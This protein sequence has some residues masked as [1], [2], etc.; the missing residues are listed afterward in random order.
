[1]VAAPAVA[2]LPQTRAEFVA[3]LVRCLNDS[4]VPW[5]WQGPTGAPAVW[6]GSDGPAD[7][8]IWWNPTPDGRERA[9][10]AVRALA[11]MAVI[12]ESRD[13]RRLQHLSLAVEIAASLAVVDF[14]EG[15]LRVGPVLLVPAADVVVSADGIDGAAGPHLVGVAGAADLLVRPL[16]RAKIPPDERLAQARARWRAADPTARLDAARRWGRELGAD[17]AAVLDVLDGAPPPDDLAQRMRRRLLKRTVAPAGLRAAWAQ[18]WSVVPAGRSAG[19]LDLRTRGVVVALVGTDGSGKSTV[20]RDLESRLGALGYRTDEAYFGMARGNLPGVALARRVLGIAAEPD[21]TEA[22][23]PSPE[24]AA[25]AAND[26]SA[27]LAEASEPAAPDLSHAGI[28]Q[29]AAWFY[30]VEYGWRYLRHVA[31]GVRRRAVVVCDR[32]VYD[33]R[34][35]P[36]PGSPAATFAQ[37]LVPAPDVLVL[38]DAPAELIHARKPE[39]RLAEQAQQQQE[40]RDLLAE[41]PARCAELVLDTSGDDPDPVAPAVA[42]VVEASHRPRP[43]RRA[44]RALRRHDGASARA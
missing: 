17:S 23:S 28:R 16:L 35:S 38:P 21:R 18:R 8:D 6:E 10:A 4:G 9:V 11:P 42:A 13:P 39:R 20:A 15:D 32:Y 44:R 5:A 29:L 43:S 26:T 14:T 24:A 3:E 30:A 12:A 1:M 7:L 36:W 40:F 22:E 2:P 37:W 34:S 33:L 27:A 25:G 19:P 31:P 41:K